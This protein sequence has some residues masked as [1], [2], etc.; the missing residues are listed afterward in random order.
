MTP[1]RQELVAQLRGDIA[2]ERVLRAIAAVDRERF[3]AEGD[4]HR[5]WENVALGIGRGQTISQPLVVARM[6]E[7][8]AVRPGGRVLDVGTG[9]G[10]HAAVLAELGAEVVGVELQAE[11]AAAAAARLPGVPVLAGD[12]RLGHPEGAPYD[13]ICVAA[14]AREP[15][16]ALIAQLA[17]GG[18]LVLP[19]RCGG[20]QRLVRLTRTAAGLRRDDH[21]AVRFVP[22]R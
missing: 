18:R 11:L 9:S 4:R 19:L 12:G 20:A 15:P 10:Y 5:A 6:C 1:T 8:L 14:A 22:L 2:D 3:V 7:L 16:P 17:D 21:E 13:G